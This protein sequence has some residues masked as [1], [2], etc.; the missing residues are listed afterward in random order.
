MKKI[1]SV[2]DS[3]NSQNIY[4]KIVYLIKNI[5]RVKGG[6]ANYLQK[7]RQSFNRFYLLT[8]QELYELYASTNDM[9]I[10][11]RHISK[12]FSEVVSLSFG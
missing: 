10:L 7:K 11:S 2:Y 3:C 6:L 5:E 9:N 4:E 12:L 8:D 1:V